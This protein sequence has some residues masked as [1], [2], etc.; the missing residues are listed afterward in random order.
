MISLVR[1]LPLIICLATAGAAHAEASL[2]DK[3]QLVAALSARG[4]CCV[5]DG[6]RAESR[7]REILKDALPWR[8]SLKINP[9]ASV[10]VV[11]DRDQDALGI[12]RTLA[13]K[14][15]GKTIL[16]VKGGV[17]TWKSAS[18]A[19]LAASA[20]GGAGGLVNFVI[21]ANTCEQ[22]KPLQELRPDKKL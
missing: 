14:H 20:E 15:P 4:P 11:A 6:R 9:T 1:A 7:R 2:A 21:P 18:F 10:V 8:S 22:G 16:A 13:R 3:A 5:I 17:A 19:L 12:A